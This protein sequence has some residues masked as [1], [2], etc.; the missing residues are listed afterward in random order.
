MSGETVA[1]HGG[2]GRL[3]RSLLDTRQQL[4]RGLREA[5]SAG[6]EELGSGSALD[7]VEAAVKSMEASGVFNAGKGAALN[8]L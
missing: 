2:A 6:L 8:A 1:V 3:R 5:L 7:A 4:E